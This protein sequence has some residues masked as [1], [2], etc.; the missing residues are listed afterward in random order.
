MGHA[1]INI[2][3]RLS[4]VAYRDLLNTPGIA[5]AHDV[6]RLVSYG[7][8]I[9]VALAID[10]PAWRSPLVLA[11]ASV[12]F[13]AALFRLGTGRGPAPYPLAY[14]DQLGT[15]IFVGVATG[16]PILTLGV[17]L[18]ISIAVAATFRADLRTSLA[19]SVL[20]AT[21][22]MLVSF[23]V[24]GGQND[25]AT[26]FGAII[27][28]AILGLALA[29]FI[30]GFFA[31]QTG[32][33]R[34]ELTAQQLQLNA[35][36]AVTPVVLATASDDGRLNILAGDLPEW[37]TLSAKPLSA[38]SEIANLIAEATSGSR[39]A[40]DI[41]IDGKTFNV[42]CD[43]GK[44][45]DVLVTASDVSAQTE[46]WRRLEGV[47]R[48]KDQFIAAV[49]HELRTPLASVLGFSEL[50]QDQMDPTDPA[51]T[52]MTEVTDQSA[53]MA[54][55]IDDLLVA[56][57][58]SF[59]SVPLS[60]RQIQLADECSTVIDSIGSRLGIT[61]ERQLSP[62]EAYADPIRVRQ[63]VRNLLTNADRYGG[64]RVIVETISVEGFSA[65]R[66]CDSGEPLPA[67]RHEQIFQPYESSGP[68]R[69]QPA[70]IGLGLAV[71][72]TLAEM[73]GGTITYH[74]NGDWSVF[75]LRLPGA[76]SASD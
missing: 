13:A 26:D 69:G 3:Q 60:P 20:T 36:L 35:V 53:E 18:F 2:W 55:I 11:I 21:P 68:V 56:A 19:L 49:S 12:L 67:E 61:P 47:V 62:L 41:D 64:D 72:R 8:G 23:L 25:T 9:A 58:A 70:A 14:I 38:D 48:S 6:Q 59:E 31:M 63:I 45:G 10:L 37:H 66:V 39:A 5:R 17:V 4:S 46:A 29:A 44:G 33:L 24:D 34:R 15:A 65:V 42:T 50:V 75:E 40:A 16:T 57:R 32:Q 76:E 73:M 74:H 1:Q 51:R 54:A 22:G 43:A 71:S 30:L 7:V 52:M 27:V 28:L